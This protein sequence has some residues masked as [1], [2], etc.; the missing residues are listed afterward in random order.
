MYA[1]TKSM[2]LISQFD[3]LGIT[4]GDSWENV[5]HAQIRQWVS[6]LSK[7]LREKMWKLFY[8]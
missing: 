1:L 5:K 7:N 6:V 3:T 4:T 2:N 8:V